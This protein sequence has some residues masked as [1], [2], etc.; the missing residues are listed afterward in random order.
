MLALVELLIVL[1]FVG[2]PV[3]GALDGIRKPDEA[4][5]AVGESKMLWITL[6]LILVFL[7]FIALLLTAAYFI[8]VRP[9]LRRVVQQQ[10]LQTG[11]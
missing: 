4:W 11:G 7:G 3:L 9:R 10:E 5:R 2:V 8:A 6:Q 1:V